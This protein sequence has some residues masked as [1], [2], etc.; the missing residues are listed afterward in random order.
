MS[1]T[2]RLLEELITLRTKPRFTVQEL[3]DEFGVSRRTM[4]RDLQALAGMGVPLAAMPGPGGGYELTPGHRLLP[5][6]LTTDEALGLLLSYEA[7]L[8]NASSPFSTQSLSAVTKVRA[9]LPPDVVA[10]LDRVRWHI[11]ILDSPRGFKAPL[12][13]E[14][15]R[16]ALVGVHLRVVYDSKSGISERLI[17]PFGLYAA[18]GFWYCA[19]YDYKR[20]MH[21]SLRAD[22]F[23]TIERVEGLDRLPHIPLSEW[24]NVVERDD[25]QQLSLRATVAAPGMKSFDLQALFGPIEPDERGDGVLTGTIP[26]SEIDWYASRLLPLGT[27]VVVHSPPE[28]IA[29]IRQ[30]AEALAGLYRSASPG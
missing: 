21:L 19:C 2:E 17:F 1:R 15:L 14:L 30:K 10:E 8:Q 7:F 29:A 27:D 4:L 23:Q 5:L 6:S 18:A 12:L 20:E 28:L 16:A 3:A 26:R 11:A 24:I 22:R 9:V 13:G 25:G